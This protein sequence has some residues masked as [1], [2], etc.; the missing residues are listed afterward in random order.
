MP[1]ADTD[2][3][4]PAPKRDAREY[5]QLCRQI[6]RLLDEGRLAEAHVLNIRARALYRQLSDS[7]SRPDDHP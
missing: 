3:S 4:Q 7:G 5:R 6:D 2:R 1:D